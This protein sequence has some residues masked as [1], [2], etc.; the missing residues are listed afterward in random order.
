MKQ[1]EI[2]RKSKQYL[3]DAQILID[4]NRFEGARYLLGYVLELALKRAICKKLSWEDYPP[5]KWKDYKSFKTHDFEILLSLSGQSSKIQR[6]FLTEWSIVSS[7][8]P[9]KLRY[10]SQKILKNDI[11]TMYRAVENIRKA[12]I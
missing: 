9:D 5:G 1:K 2:V 4:N 7:W 10:V 12:I 11:L 3:K 8:S 6:K